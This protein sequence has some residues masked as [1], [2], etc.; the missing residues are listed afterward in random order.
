MGEFINNTCIGVTHWI[1]RLS[2]AV[3]ATQF[4]VGMTKIPQTTLALRAELAVFKF[5]V[6]NFGYILVD[7][8]KSTLVRGYI[9]AKLEPTVILRKF[10]NGLNF[11]R[12]QE[13]IPR[14]DLETYYGFGTIESTVFKEKALNILINVPVHHTNGFHKVYRAIPSPQPIE[15]DST[16]TRYLLSRS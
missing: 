12:V 7:A 4:N 16:A 8:S 6:H 10:L 3:V 5:G 1:N 11:D 14:S 13:A 9:P 15:D 2:S